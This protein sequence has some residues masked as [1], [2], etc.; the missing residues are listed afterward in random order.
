MSWT[1]KATSSLENSWP[2]SY[3]VKVHLPYELADL[4]L[5]VSP[6]EVETDVHTK[7]CP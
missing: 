6:G 5:G 2:A 4:R 7:T 3:N 1:G